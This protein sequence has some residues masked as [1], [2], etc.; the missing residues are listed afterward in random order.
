[1]TKIL[2]KTINDTGLLKKKD[3]KYNSNEC[4]K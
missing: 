3:P 2:N 4:I 1:M